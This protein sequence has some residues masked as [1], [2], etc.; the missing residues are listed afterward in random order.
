VIDLQDLGLDRMD[1]SDDTLEL[2]SGVRLQSLV[3]SDVVPEILRESARREAGWNLRNAA[4][5]GGTVA[6][7]DGRSPLLT[8]LLALRAEILI[9]PEGSWV[10]LD[11][12]LS[13]RPDSLRGRLM[14]SARIRV[15]AAHGYD[16]V[17]R[18]PADAPIVCVAAALLPSRPPSVALGGFGQ[19]PLR[20][21]AEGGVTRFVQA[22]SLAYSQAED[23]WAGAAYRSEVAGVL[24]RRT[25]EGIGLK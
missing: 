22:A 15:P 18:T 11:L 21:V 9:E 24:V 6:A 25:L 8:V 5:L 1:R 23:A 14:T 20:L 10:D 7:G 13:G 16:Q 19:A 4:T 2:G 17:A 3:D 12:V